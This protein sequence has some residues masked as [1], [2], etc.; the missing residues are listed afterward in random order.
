MK[1]EFKVDREFILQAYDE[2]SVDFKAKMED[3]FPDIFLKL[4]PKLWYKKE[5]EDG[6]VDLFFVE[7]IEGEIF[8]FGENYYRNG[9]LLDTLGTTSSSINLMFTDD[10]VRLSKA[11]HKEVEEV[12]TNDAKR[13]GF[14]EGVEYIC[15]FDGNREIITKEIFTLDLDGDLV[16]QGKSQGGY[17]FYKGEWAKPI[18]NSIIKRIEG[19][20]YELKELKESL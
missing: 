7:S 18:K 15:L 1:T 3:K 20:E 12:L 16:V 5:W 11:S 13:R 2:V 10:R 4:E 9:K 19:L 17:V 14:I 8:S 6:E